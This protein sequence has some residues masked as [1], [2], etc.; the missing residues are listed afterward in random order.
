M[1]DGGPLAAELTKDDVHR[2]RL[3]SEGPSVEPG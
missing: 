2:L 1:T 3:L